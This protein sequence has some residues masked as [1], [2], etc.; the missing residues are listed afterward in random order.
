M[1]VEHTHYSAGL[2]EIPENNVLD[3][4]GVVAVEKTDPKQTKHWRCSSKAGYRHRFGMNGRR[5]RAV[6]K[7]DLRVSKEGQRVRTAAYRLSVHARYHRRF[8]IQQSGEAGFVAVVQQ[9]L[10][11]QPNRLEA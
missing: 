1:R 7:P 11:S 2:V 5:E 4:G 6:A 8:D 10:C 3:S 9:R